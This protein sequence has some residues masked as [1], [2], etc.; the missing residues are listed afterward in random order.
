MVKKKKPGAK[1]AALLDKPVVSK[2][3]ELKKQIDN[4]GRIQR[5]C[6]ALTKEYKGIRKN[7]CKL[8]TQTVGY[9]K[10]VEG[11]VHRAIYSHDLESYIDPVKLF[12]EVDDDKIL[13][14][15]LS[16]NLGMAKKILKRKT[17]NKL[18]VQQ[19]KEVPTLHIR[20]IS[21]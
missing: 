15:L 8:F 19:T 18:L 10:D 5:E 12:E 16:V 17:Y 3:D 1:L 21:S 14:V 13:R 4:G 2:I 11:N 20:P 9:D 6:N 7:I